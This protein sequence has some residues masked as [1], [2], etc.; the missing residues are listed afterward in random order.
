MSLSRVEQVKKRKP[1]APWDL[2]VYGLLAVLILV[3]FAVFVFGADK[4]P[5]SG[6]RIESEGKV[7]YSYSFE[8]GAEIPAE[9]RESVSEKREDGF[10][11]VTVTEEGGHGYNVLKID[12]ARKTA[13]MV[14]TDCSRH[15]DCLYM[16]EIASKS[17]VIVCVPHGLKVLALDGEEDFD[18]PVLG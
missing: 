9:F 4:S 10:L 16:A 7:I 1:F 3:L 5:V 12:L 2:L 15:K 13:K 11:F 17:G 6:F 8:K 14:D 18:H